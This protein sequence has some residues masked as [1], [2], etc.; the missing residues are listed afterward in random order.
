MPAVIDSANSFTSKHGALR[1]LHVRV[2]ALT[3]KPI[4]YLISYSMGLSS[5]YLEDGVVMKKKL[6]PMIVQNFFYLNKKKEKHAYLTISS[7]ISK[8]EGK[9]T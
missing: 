2:K 7:S 3:E 9:Y 6:T 1:H 5:L 4:D 8:T